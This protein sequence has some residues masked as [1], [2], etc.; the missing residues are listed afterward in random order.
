LWAL[1]QPKGNGLAGKELTSAMVA[2]KVL[3]VDDENLLGLNISLSYE[4]NIQETRYQNHRL[5]LGSL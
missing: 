5:P 3:L 4:E 2:K 1:A